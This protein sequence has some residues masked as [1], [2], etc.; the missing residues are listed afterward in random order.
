MSNTHMD[1][2]PE[3]QPTT[4]WTDKP[5]VDEN[6]TTDTATEDEAKKPD[7]GAEGGGNH[8]QKDPGETG[9]KKPDDAAE[10]EKKEKDGE[11]DPEPVKDGVQKRIDELTKKRR[12]AERRVSELEA[13]LEQ[14]RRAAGGETEQA[15][16]LTERPDPD[17]FET[18]EEYE[19]ALVDW[20]IDQR[21]AKKQADD[22]AARQERETTSKAARLNT[23]MMDG[24]AAYPDFDQVTRNPALQFSQAMAEAALETDDPTE[25]IYHLAKNPEESARIARL[26]PLAAAREIGKIEAALTKNKETDSG[27]DAEKELEQAK[28]KTK[29]PD[30][31]NPLKGNEVVKKDPAKMSMKE[32]AAAREKGEI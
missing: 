26:S 1:L 7:E 8:E 19:E 25:I 14:H 5:A 29:A 24:A 6:G 15:A 3:A 22:E 18:Y 31:I 9:E 21:E 13:E 12:E 17:D 30:P 10:Q 20:K 16:Q 28:R 11:H 32:Y 2:K 27:S 4:D 23:A